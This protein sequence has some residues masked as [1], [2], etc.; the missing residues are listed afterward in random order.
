M[1]RTSNTKLKL[2]IVVVNWDTP[3]LT[4]DC[5][6]TIYKFKPSHP[7]EVILVNNGFVGISITELVDFQEV[8]LINTGKNLGFS[9]A[10][11]L[12]IYN[13]IGDFIVLLNSDT[14]LIDH[15]FD[16]MLA[17]MDRDENRHVG[18]LGTREV[19]GEQRFRLSCGAFPTFFSELT[20]K[21]WHYRLSLNDYNL[22]DYL[23]SKHGA[24]R[25]VDWIS[26]SC[27]MLRRTALHST[28]LLDENFF[29]YFEDIDLCTRLWR[30]K[31]EV[32]YLPETSIVHY[33]GGSARKDLMLAMTE[34]RRSEIYFA[35]KYYGWLGEFAISFFLFFKYT[36][37]FLKSYPEYL[38][39]K[40][41]KRN[42]REAFATALLSKKVIG[43]AFRSFSATP[44]EPRL[45]LRA[46]GRSVRSHLEK[47]E[48]GRSESAN[49]VSDHFFQ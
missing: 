30:K 21:I 35:K 36:G 11:N 48:K 14:K 25:D 28:G 31:W 43:M 37:Y 5:I 32:H 47:I 9:K 49:S 12:G 23:D 27:M 15:S 10:N 24:M 3:E 19:D 13:S 8:R 7:F 44:I 4:L 40:I 17:Y 38:V 22:R 39:R 16:K 33:G 42:Y 34:Y 26:G 45:T 20:R 29:L 1:D 46:N 41:F 6:R 2:S 18:A